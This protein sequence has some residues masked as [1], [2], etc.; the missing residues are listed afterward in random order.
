MSARDPQLAY[1]I[2]HAV[3]DHNPG[4]VLFGLSGSAS[5]KEA[6][7]LGL[8]TMSEVFADRSYQPDG[9]LTPRSLPGALIE[10]EEQCT[11]QVRDMMQKGS[12]MTVEG[13]YIPIRAQTICL[14]GDGENA[15][16]FARLIHGIVNS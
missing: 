3:M 2:A 16:S 6:E 5:I 14:H 13:E 7:K 15:V 10:S 4:L 8:K 12:V 11:S 1:I 9:S